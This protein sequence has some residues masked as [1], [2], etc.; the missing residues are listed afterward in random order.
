MAL[1]NIFREPRREI[2]EQ[3]FGMALVGGII[4]AVYWLS[5]WCFGPDWYDATSTAGY[6]G[7]RFLTMLIIGGGTFLAIIAT[8]GA[9]YLAHAAGELICELMAAAG[10]DPRPRQRY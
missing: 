2:I 8:I 3:F 4:S 10:F 9:W 7:E 1:S 6:I 5:G